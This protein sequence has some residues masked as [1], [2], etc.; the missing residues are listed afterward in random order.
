MRGGCTRI[1]CISAAGDGTTSF[2]T[3]GEA[4]AL[5]REELGVEFDIELEYLRASDDPQPAPGASGPDAGDAPLRRRLLRG[6]KPV[7]LARRAWARGTF[8]Y[9]PDPNTPGAEPVEGTLCR[10]ERWRGGRIDL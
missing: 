1:Y 4:L 5:A 7:P 3:V 10:V 6:G 9:P 8:T 2:G